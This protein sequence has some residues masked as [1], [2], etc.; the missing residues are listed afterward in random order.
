MNE[1]LLA[2][3]LAKPVGPEQPKRELQSTDLTKEL[4]LSGNTLTAV[5]TDEPGVVNEGTARDFLTDEGLNPDDWEVTGF[6]KSQWESG[7][8]LRESVRFTY[9]RR[10]E[11]EAER[12]PL[13]LDDLLVALEDYEPVAVRPQGSH[14][15]LVLIGDMQFGKIDGDGAAGTLRRTIECINK[16][17]DLLLM[18]SQWYDIGHIHIAWLGDHIEGFVSQGGAN[19]WRTNLTLNE[20]IRLTQAVMLHALKTFAPLADKVTMAAVPGNHGES[21]RFEG[22]GT[23]RYDDSHDTEALISIHNTIKALEVPGYEHV[24]FYVPDTDELTVQIEVAGTRILH[25]HGHK[26][27]TKKDAH[28]EWWKGQEFGREGLPAHLL[29]AGHLHNE[30]STENFIQVPAMESESTWYRHI[31]GTV[32][33]PGLIVALTKDGRT[34]I[35]HTVNFTDSDTPKGL[36]K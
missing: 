16:A 2:E 35:K 4:E 27:G 34:P 21:V 26:F 3:L 28:L 9:R 29:V 23:T 15:F 31:H 7:D 24:N 8:N 25:A 33:T 18:Y 13:L 10:I 20:Q 12:P 32:S 5:L 30:F 1:E 14:G 22:K 19:V 11:G 17:A 36:G 6:R